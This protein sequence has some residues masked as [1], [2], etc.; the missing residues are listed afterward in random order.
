V[1]ALVE[2]NKG[3]IWFETPASWADEAGKEIKKGTVF[4]FTIPITPN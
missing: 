2:M 4:H 3:K 1:K